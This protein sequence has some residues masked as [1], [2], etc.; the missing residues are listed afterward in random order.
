MIENDNYFTD[1]DFCDDLR[2]VKGQDIQPVSEIET[3]PEDVG[4]SNTSETKTP[5]TVE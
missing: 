2:S 3:R 4:L 1:A 5:W